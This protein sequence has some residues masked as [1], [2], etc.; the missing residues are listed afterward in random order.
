MASHQVCFPLA[1]SANDSVDSAFPVTPGLWTQVLEP[2]ASGQ[3]TALGAPR[4]GFS[5]LHGLEKNWP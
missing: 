5:L 4:I 3:P 1:S 2:E